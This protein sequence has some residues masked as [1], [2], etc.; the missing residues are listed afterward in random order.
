MEY[1]VVIA[2]NLTDLEDYVNEQ[3]TRGYVPQGGIFVEIEYT[4]DV[5]GR[6]YLQAMIKTIKKDEK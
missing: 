3:I 4:P 6:N 2:S 1:K 5:S